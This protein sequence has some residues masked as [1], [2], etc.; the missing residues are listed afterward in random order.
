[1]STEYRAE[2]GPPRADQAVDRLY[3]KLRG[4]FGFANARAN[5]YR[6][7]DYFRR[8]Q[9]MVLKALGRPRG[10]VL[11]VACGSGLMLRPIRSDAAAIVGIDYNGDASRQARDNGIAVIRGDAFALP[12]GDE[13]ADM[14]VNCQFLNQQSGAAARRLIE[15][16][17]RVLKPGGNLVA[18]W[19]NG[20][21]MI[22]RLAHPLCRLSDRLRGLP[23][24]PCVDHPIEE[25]RGHA[26]AA[27]LRVEAAAAVFPPL[28]WRI[29]DPE[30]L[31]AR[32]F[33]AS[34]LM[35]L[36]KPAAGED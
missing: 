8:E 15:E 14:A 24:F 35:V 18:V 9:K 7:H 30:S 28:N 29:A 4:R 25:M 10:V 32:L 19:R 11:D 16:V 1:M 23:T 2:P 31:A 33:G 27:G 17:G 21:S 12:L 13:T 6:Y 34:Y 3:G 5:G 20:G 26:A 22:H 36:R